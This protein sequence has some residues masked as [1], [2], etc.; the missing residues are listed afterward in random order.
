[1]DNDTLIRTGL[2]TAV[3]LT[4][5]AI[6]VLAGNARRGLAPL[7]GIAG[8]AMLAVTVV[9]LLPEAWHSLRPLE[10]ALSVASGY[11]LLYLIGRYVAPVCPACAAASESH[12]ECECG[13][14]HGHDPHGHDREQ[15]D[16]AHGVR[17]TLANTTLLLAAVLTLHSLVDGMAVAGGA[18]AAHGGHHHDHPDVLP[19]LLAVSL[20]KL[21]EG[22]ALSALLLSAGSAPLRAFLLTAAVEATTILGGVLGAQFFATAP[23]VWL[24]VALA[25]IG[26][27]FLYLVLHGLLG[28]LWSGS[29][30]AALRRAAPQIGYGTIGFGGIALLLWGLLHFQQR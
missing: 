17:G 11:L 22:L 2:A 20:H 18:A 9:S 29:P 12:E 15:H 19:M 7:V 21:P 27:S 23:P 8:G 13:D 6:G 3:A 25:H 16:H 4:G 24:G 30:N 5:G 10:F 28:G 1:M 14:D 26:G